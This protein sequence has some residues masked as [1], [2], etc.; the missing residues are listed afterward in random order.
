MLLSQ[1]RPKSQVVLPERLVERPA[2][3]VVD[4]HNHVG[5]WLASDSGWVAPGRDDLDALLDAARV[6]TLV[7]LDGRWGQELVDNVVR[8]DQA[9]RRYVTFCHVDW[10]RLVE[11]S[12]E[13][14]HAV[15]DALTAQ[16][17]ESARAGARGVKVWKDLGLSIRDATGALV[18]PNDRRVVAVLQAAGD[19]GLPVLIHTADPV[20]FFEPL[21]EHNE[22][23]EELAAMPDWWFGAPGYPPFGELI[24]ALHDLVSACPKTVFVGAHLG[25]HAEDLAAVGRA[26]D[27]L[28][29]WH[30]DTGGRL[31][32]IGR[33]PRA[34]RRLVEAYPDRVLFGSDCFPPSLAEYRRWW[35]FLETDDEHFSYV[36]EGEIPLQGRWRISGAA[37]PKGLLR[38]LYRDNAHRILGL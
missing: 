1:W 32:E 3:D 2:F 8:Y 33:Q 26:L 6:E 30:V 38:A 16:L 31:G 24:A 12:G 10:S 23:I 36:D 34:F 37:L 25:C 35:R 4:L 14:D 13:N 22:R 18:R 5:R 11:S 17:A 21:D 29:N 9:S 27:R 15:V 20:A 28:P 19:L 7:N